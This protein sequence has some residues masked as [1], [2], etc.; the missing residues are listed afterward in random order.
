MRTQRPHS[1]TISTHVENGQ[2]ISMRFI[3]F[4][5]ISTIYVCR[6][7]CVW[8]STAH[9][10]PASTRHPSSPSLSSFLM[11]NKIWN[12][13]PM[14]ISTGE[15][16]REGDGEIAN[17]SNDKISLNL[18]LFLFDVTLCVTTLIFFHSSEVNVHGANCE[19]DSL[20]LATRTFV[21]FRF[22]CTLHSAQ[23]TRIMD[24]C[25]KLNCSWCWWDEWIQAKCAIRV[26]CTYIPYSIRQ[27]MA[28]TDNL[29]KST[30]KRMCL[31]HI[32]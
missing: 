5:F 17:R 21:C 19:S 25:F 27:T 29:I 28:E 13:R 15:G 22:V 2:H 24:L 12:D 31:S 11:I 16:K 9:R 8:L 26:E 1:N 20:K 10:A 3:T 18:S 7:E 23:C 4:I 30:E 6:M 14:M 32:H